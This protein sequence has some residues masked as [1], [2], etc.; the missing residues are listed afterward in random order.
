MAVM[1]A[2]I[3]GLMGLLHVGAGTALAADKQ[4]KD[5]KVIHHL[6]LR[7]TYSERP[8]GA[9][10]DLTS[11]V[12]GGGLSSKSYFKL[13]DHIDGLAE[14]KEIDAL[15]LDLS[16]PF[17]LGRVNTRDF[18]RRMAGLK[19]A[20]IRT[21]AW[22]G[23]LDTPV[24]CVAATCD[25]IY[26]AKDGMVD[27]PS[28]TMSHTFLKDLF[29]LLGVS[30]TAVRA[31]DFKGAVEPYTR[32]SMSVHLRRHYQQLLTSMNDASVA[33]I[34]AGRKLAPKVVR[35]LQQ[36]RMMQPATAQQA[37]LVDKLVTPGRM[38][39]AVA[40]A[41][42]GTVEWTAPKKAKPKSFGL[43]DLFKALAG[44]DDKSA[45]QTK[46]TVVVYHLN[47]EI[48]DGHKPSSGTIVDGPAVKDLDALRE[49]EQVKAV[50]IRID[51]PGG[52]AT[53]SENIRVAIDKLAAKKPVV[54]SMAGTAASGGYLVACVDA[55]IYADA[56]T[57]TGSIG[58]FGMSIGFDS[59]LRRVGVNME[60]VAIDEAARQMQL[61]KPW[62]DE[63][64]AKLQVHVDAT[65]DLF[66]NRVSQAR[67][68]PV[69]KLKSLAGGRVWTGAQ[70]KAHGLVDH[71]GGLHASLEAVRAKAKL[72]DDD[73][74]EIKHLPKARE[75]LDL[76]GLLGDD[77]EIFH[78]ELQR[79][80]TKL[81]ALG[82]DTRPIEFLLRHA[83]PAEGRPKAMKMWMLHPMNFKIH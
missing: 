71:L 51:S 79:Q 55:P 42:G 54:F 73:K 80:F 8:A 82:I 10:L 31:G 81:N 24:L 50:V 22:V 26:L 48:V 60:T 9:S 35:Q 37:G 20:G 59:L 13:A 45:K 77:D 40:K 83:R 15:V 17:M 62:S 12:M 19:D 38:R 25:E 52:S 69:E 18:A 66:L 11:L 3:F 76:S 2:A 39:E 34:A 44:G 41:V 7:G 46:P 5:A 27:I 32:A 72:G 74:V 53:A 56:D 21:I 61:G 78:G 4:A 64:L 47:G 67:D 49:D 58:V 33:Q 29:N 16:Q 28:A 23:S 57:V 68:I 63:E 30:V 6:T 43:S 65:Y 36:N 75:G 70:A 14:A 1:A